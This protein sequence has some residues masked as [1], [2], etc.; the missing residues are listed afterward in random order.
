MRTEFNGGTDYEE[1][2]QGGKVTELT[3]EEQ[4][5]LSDLC[6]EIRT[7]SRTKHELEKRLARDSKTIKLLKQSHRDKIDYMAK[8]F[9]LS[10]VQVISK[11]L[12]ENKKYK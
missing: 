5:I 10:R 12:V 4:N 8:R 3:G 7:E 6:T 9:D 11:I 1:N 2:P